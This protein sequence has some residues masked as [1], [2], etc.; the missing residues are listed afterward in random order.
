MKSIR[1]VFSGLFALLILVSVGLVASISLVMQL[2]EADESAEVL[3]GLIGGRVEDLV[4]LEFRELMSL[5]RIYARQIESKSTTFKDDLHADK[6]VKDMIAS[7]RTQSLMTKAM[8]LSFVDRRGKC[9]ALDRRRTA[10]PVVKLC[11][12]AK[13]GDIRWY[14]FE[15]YG[16]SQEPLAKGLM[17]VDI[18]EDKTFSDA[19]MRHEVMT[20]GLH[21]S[22]WNEESQVVSVHEPLF[23]AK[24]DF[25]LMVSADL[26]VRSLAVYL[27]S[28]KAPDGTSIIL[29]DGSG[30]LLSSSIR[31]SD[32]ESG[33]TNPNDFPPISGNLDSAIRAANLALHE[34]KG[35]YA[36]EVEKTFHIKYEDE[37]YYVYVAPVARDRG[38]DWSFAIAIPQSGLINHILYGIRMT[39]WVTGGLVIL[40]IALGLLLAAWITR[41]I[42]TLGQAAR[43]LEANQLDEPALPIKALS[44]DAQLSN[45]FGRLATLFLQMIEEVR[46]RHRLLEIQLEQLR[47]DVREEETELE[48][49]AIAETEFFENLRA[50]AL[51]LRGTQQHD[52]EI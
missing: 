17:H 15:G 34:T 40:A 45:E 3:I 14:S 27:Q 31:Q 49:R 32:E 12:L 9:L 10:T 25:R 1:F 38:Q 13:S 42:L 44:K 41:P 43:A 4:D 35:G 5:E 39:G 52:V 2:R 50:N 48:V 8:T 47:V 30:R 16:K 21:P 23:D 6:F 7:V 28:L 26:D 11:D 24:G 19:I 36:V 22:Y 37:L 18:R 29:F 20:S 33:V 46:S 51:K